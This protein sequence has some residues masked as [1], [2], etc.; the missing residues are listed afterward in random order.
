M[1]IIHFTDKYL[2]Y[3]FTYMCLPCDRKYELGRPYSC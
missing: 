1:R 3:W 2:F